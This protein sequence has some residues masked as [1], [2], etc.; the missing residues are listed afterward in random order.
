MVAGAELQSSSYDIS[1]IDNELACPTKP[2]Q[3]KIFF[4]MLVYADNSARMF[5]RMIDRHNFMART[6][7]VLWQLSLNPL[8]PR[9]L[10]AKSN[11][12]T[13]SFGALDYRTEQRSPR[14]G[15]LCSISILQGKTT[16]TPLCR[17]VSLPQM[18]V[19]LL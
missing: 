5:W 14:L 15:S 7:K 17:S 12:K 10:Q 16:V 2:Q 18:K 9:L 8:D 1:D 19:V 11:P 13:A 4:F 6:L 3:Y